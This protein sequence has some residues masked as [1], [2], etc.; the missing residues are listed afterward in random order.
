[1]QTMKVALVK[2]SMHH[3]TPDVVSAYSWE[4][5]RPVIRCVSG[6]IGTGLL[7]ALAGA[8]VGGI[9]AVAGAIGGGILGALN[10]C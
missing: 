5:W 9:G 6:I 8:G 2:P 10:Y 1:M 4:E 3:S 7:G